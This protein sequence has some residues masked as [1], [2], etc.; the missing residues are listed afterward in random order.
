MNKL[1][2][3]ERMEALIASWVGTKRMVRVPLQGTVQLAFFGNLSCQM[4]QDS[5]PQFL[6]TRG[7]CPSPA[8]VFYIKDVLCIQN[9]DGVN[10]QIYLKP[11]LDIGKLI[12]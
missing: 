10:P 6:I 12:E 2:E 11:V 5:D 8:L 7:E 9:A 1:M 3:L 4:D